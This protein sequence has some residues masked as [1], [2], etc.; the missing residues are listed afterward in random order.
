MCI[1][2]IMMTYADLLWLTLSARIVTPEN[3]GVLIVGAAA[4]AIPTPIYGAQVQP[5]QPVPVCF[6]IP[7]LTEP[8]AFILSSVFTERNTQIRS[9]AAYGWIED[10]LIYEPRAEVMGITSIGTQPVTFVRDLDLDVPPIAYMPSANA[11]STLVRLAGVVIASFEHTGPALQLEGTMAA[12]AGIS[13][14]EPAF[15]GILRAE[16]AGGLSLRAA[17]KP[18]R[19]SI[20]PALV[21]LADGWSL[22]ARATQCILVNPQHTDNTLIQQLLVG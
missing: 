16:V 10:N 2:A 9:L 11:P 22:L 19:R 13:S 17:L 15:G 7:L 6:G 4:T 20:D 18:R 3:M 8:Y 5:M 12:L 21:A 14:A 1:K